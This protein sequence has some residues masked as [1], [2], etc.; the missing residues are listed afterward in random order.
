MGFFLGFNEDLMV[1]TEDIPTNMRIEFPEQYMILIDTVVIW[2][3]V[4]GT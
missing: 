2:L 4:T 1:F 3:V